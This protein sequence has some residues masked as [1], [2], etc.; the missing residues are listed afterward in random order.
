MKYLRDLAARNCLID[1]DSFTLKLADF[2]LSKEIE[3]DQEENIYF[4]KRN[5]TIPIRWAA[6]ES[7]TRGIWLFIFM[8][9]LKKSYFFP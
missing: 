1:D 4:M 6:I 8:I 3:K 5:K 2:G 7:F 9:V